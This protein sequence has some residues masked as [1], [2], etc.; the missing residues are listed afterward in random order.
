MSLLSMFDKPSELARLIDECTSEMQLNTDWALNM[1]VCDYV[2][3]GGTAAAKDAIKTIRKKLKSSSSNPKTCLLTLTLLEML[4]KNGR[5]E[6]HLEASNS[7][8]LKDLEEL[9]TSSKTDVRVRDKI[10]E[11]I[12]SWADA[13]NAFK[14]DLPM[15]DALYVRMKRQGIPFPDRDLSGMVPIITPDGSHGGSRMLPPQMEDTDAYGRAVS[16]SAQPPLST[17]S[18]APPAAPPPQPRMIDSRG[19]SQ[20]PAYAAA[21]GYVAAPTMVAL[22]P[23][24]AH[25]VQA[26]YGARN[27]HPPSYAA[28][29][30]LQYQ[31]APPQAYSLPPHGYNPH[32]AQHVP[33]Y[34][35]THPVRPPHADAGSSWLQASHGRQPAAASDATRTA[36]LASLKDFIASCAAAS[37]LYASLVAAGDGSDLIQDLRVQ[38]MSLQDRLSKTIPDIQNEELL[39]QALAINDDMLAAL[40]GKPASAAAAPAPGQREGNLLGFDSAPSSVPA[41]AAVP[42]GGDSFM[43]DLFGASAAF[44][45]QVSQAP[46]LPP[47]WEILVDQRGQR[48]Y[49]HPG[50]KV[51]QYEHPSLGVVQ[52]GP[53]PVQQTAALLPP[54][55]F[56][57]QQQPAIAPSQSFSHV[58][59]QQPSAPPP[60]FHAAPAPAPAPL[61][62]GAPQP[63]SPSLPPSPAPSSAPPPEV[64]SPGA[65]P[66]LSMDAIPG[67]RAFMFV[68]IP[69]PLHAHTHC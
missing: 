29:R 16:S 36:T 54:P 41:G 57:A 32:Q 40:S 56:R 63:S 25:A 55:P 19:Y 22:A 69:V 39:L 12:Q 17:A 9:A 34:Y 7:S 8:F 51:T 42:T 27:Q 2:N 3:R 5:A 62:Q 64:T 48:Y 65:A 33:E 35:A 47:G 10:L 66:I 14:D 44:A 6:L 15:F 26:Q 31:H 49:G 68:F 23:S 38:C 21:P 18:R 50:L 61:A 4:M 59:A 28:P 58:P 1:Q 45:P 52:R 20:H 11:L 13:F 43:D 30:P 37:E 53:Q 60:A 24:H 67:T 46:P